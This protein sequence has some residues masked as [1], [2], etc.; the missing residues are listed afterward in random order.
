M[1]REVGES[2]SKWE[3]FFF[4]WKHSDG[5]KSSHG[6]HNAHV[7]VDDFWLAQKTLRR[8]REIASA[9]QLALKAT[10]ATG[11]TRCARCMCIYLT[12]LRL[13]MFGLQ[14]SLLKK[15][16]SVTHTD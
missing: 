11:D 5:A 15:L 16:P 1:A 10:W 14:K 12:G 9:D 13:S 7:P 6:W 2:Y 4:F 8:V 3:P